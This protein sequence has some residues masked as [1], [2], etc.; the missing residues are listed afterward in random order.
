MVHKIFD[1]KY[2][3]DYGKL[4][5][6]N[7]IQLHLLKFKDFKIVNTQI[8]FKIAGG[9]HY[10][11]IKNNQTKMLNMV[12]KIVNIYICLNYLHT[13]FAKIYIF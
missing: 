10:F 4:N 2:K 6:P 5:L 8:K 12:P 11:K 7:S 13:L 3:I 1:I 9:N